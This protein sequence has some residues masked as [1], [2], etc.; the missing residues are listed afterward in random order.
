[1]TAILVAGACGGSVDSGGGGGTAKVTIAGR[2]FDV[3]NVEMTLETGD[4]G[5]FRIDG[6]DAANPDKDCLTGLSGGLA[7][8]GELPPTVTSL[9]D[10]AGQ[11]LPSRGLPE[12]WF[13]Q[14][15]GSA[16]I[17]EWSASRAPAKAC[18]PSLSM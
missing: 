7:L 2:T 18:G 9:N 3:K 17:D 6:D 10:L 8:Y 11:E 12:R 14:Q 5:Y 13:R 4:D 16:W 1:M 15:P